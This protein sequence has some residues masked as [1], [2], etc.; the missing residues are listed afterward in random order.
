MNSFDEQLAEI[1]SLTNTTKNTD[2]AEVLGISPKTV[3]TWRERQKIPDK[4]Y[5]MAKQIAKKNGGIAPMMPHGYISI[6]MY[7]ADEHG[8]LIQSNE[9]PPMIFSESFI[10]SELKT[11]PVELFMMMADGDSMAPTLKQ[12]SPVVIHRQKLSNDGI[13][14][15]TFKNQLMIKRLQFLRN[16]IN[17][18][19]DNHDYEAWEL[20]DSEINKLQIVGKVVWNGTFI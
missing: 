13:Y 16:G 8:Q 18:I 4:I 20:D 6:D 15:F 17:V 14:V 5:L 2:L 11:K 9:T 10:D 1:K 19:S 7:R 3:S 12:G